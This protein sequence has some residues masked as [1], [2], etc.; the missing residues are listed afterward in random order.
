[1]FNAFIHSFMRTALKCQRDTSHALM[2]TIALQRSAARLKAMHSALRP[3]EASD[4]LVMRSCVE[5]GVHVHIAIRRQGSSL[6][7]RE[8]SLEL[9]CE[10]DVRPALRRQ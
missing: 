2:Y 7:R 3:V 8:R 9:E 6:S 1:M 10:L 4:D 5:G